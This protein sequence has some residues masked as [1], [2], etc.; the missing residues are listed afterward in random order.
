MSAKLANGLAYDTFLHQEKDV[1][2]AIEAGQPVV[3]IAYQAFCDPARSTKH[4]VEE[5]ARKHG[6][7]LIRIDCAFSYDPEMAGQLI[8]EVRVHRGT[9]VSPPLTGARTAQAVLNFLV[10]NGVVVLPESTPQ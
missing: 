5:Y 9:Q 7:P 3:T 1:Q 10:I 6:F 8:P 2:A 4:Y